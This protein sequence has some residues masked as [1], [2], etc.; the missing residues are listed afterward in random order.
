[1]ITLIERIEARKAIKGLKSLLDTIESAM[2]RGVP[3]AKHTQFVLGQI[4]QSD[5]IEEQYSA[6]DAWLDNTQSAYMD[7]LRAAARDSLS[8]FAEYLNP[9]EPP[10][11]HHEWMCARLEELE[12]RKIMRLMISMPPGHAKS[13]YCT[14]LFPAWYMGRNPN[15][16]Y[17]QGGHTQDFVDEEFGKKV[18]GNIDSIAFS[19]VFPGVSLHPF[20]KAAG[21]FALNVPNKG[22]YLTRGVGQGLAGFRGNVVAIDDPFATRE[23]AESATIRQKVYNWYTA[24]VLPRMLPRSPVLVVATRWHTDDLCGRLE[25]MNADKIGLP[26]MIVNLPALAEANDPLGRAEGEPLWGDFYTLDHLLNLRDTLPSRD[27]NSLYQGKPMDQMGGAFQQ[28]WIKRYDTH[29]MN[30]VNSNGNVVRTHIRRVVVSVD[31]ASKTNER[32]DYTAISVWI[33]DAFRKHY[34][35][36]V[37]RRRVEFNEMVDLI[38]GTVDKWNGNLQGAKV[39]AILVEDKGSGTQ[40]IQT[41][42]GK[43]PAP[44]IPIEVGVNSKEFRFDG[45]LPMFEGGE[46]LLPMQATWLAEYEAELLS[47]PTGTYDDQVD[48]TS[49]YLAWARSRRIGGTKKLGGVGLPANET[50]QP[51]PIHRP[52]S[53]SGSRNRRD[54]GRW[55]S[56]HTPSARIA[57]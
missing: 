40:Y 57:G 21:R 39:S 33:E 18:R 35:V 22:K 30:E 4:V 50:Q 44:V 34:L 24:D 45:I 9:E 3:L 43:A 38:E 49:Q 25:K 12:A 11:A 14:H 1:M 51:L 46:V 19:E 32:N 47:F 7:R 41:R 54:A 26:W 8:C 2:H 20:S 42:T 53:L 23:D 28:E 27:W 31:T 5:D 52:H 56:T 6:V 37:I 16:K 10:A 13:T 17:I 15:H 55:A 48:T 29:P 36:D